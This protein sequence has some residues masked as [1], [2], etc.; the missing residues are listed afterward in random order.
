LSRRH[1]ISATEPDLPWFKFYV[2]DFLTDQDVILMSPAERGTYVTLMCYC[3]LEG[4]LP[5]APAKLARLCN[6]S[7][8]E[9]DDLWGTLER[10]FVVK[11]DRLT[12]PRL[13]GLR[14]EALTQRQRQSE[15]GRRGAERRWHKQRDG[16]AMAYP[17]PTHRLTT[18]I[19]DAEAEVGGIS[20]DG[21]SLATN[22]ARRDGQLEGMESVHDGL[23]SPENYERIERE[24]IQNEHQG[25]GPSLRRYHSSIAKLMNVEALESLA[26]RWREHAVTLERFGAHQHAGLLRTCADE[27]DRKLHAWLDEPL[28]V[29]QAAVESHYSE[30]HLR[31]LLKDEIVPNAGRVGRPRI[32]RQDLPR[33]PH[34]PDSVSL[35]DEALRLRLTR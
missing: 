6:V 3:W 27:L 29:P 12:H 7:S 5:A 28:A 9:F 26:A 32:R 23:C 8:A 30:S 18:G 17:S 10:H 15:G 1:D 25:R 14:K 2:R 20:G 22:A 16:S 35:A 13:D 4:S 11:R 31:A 24:A 34:R 21:R 33:K 19:S